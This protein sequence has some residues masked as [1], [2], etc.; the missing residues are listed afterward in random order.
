MALTTLPLLACAELPEPDVAGETDAGL[1]DAKLAILAAQGV[2]ND[3]FVAIDEAQAGLPEAVAAAEAAAAAQVAYDDG[4]YSDTIG[5]I[6][7]ALGSL[8]AVGVEVPPEAEM[9]LK[10]AQGLLM[11]VGE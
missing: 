3:A 1:R 2:L 7:K 9:H 4:R 6:R 11:L 10:R 5:E 8:A